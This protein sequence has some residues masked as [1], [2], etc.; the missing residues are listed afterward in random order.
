MIGDVPSRA[1]CIFIV[2]IACGYSS[3]IKFNEWRV[4]TN[5]KPRTKYNCLNVT[6]VTVS[7]HLLERFLILMTCWHRSYRKPL[8]SQ[9]LKRLQK[10]RRYQYKSLFHQWTVR[11][12]RIKLRKMHIHEAQGGIFKSIGHL[13]LKFSF[14]LWQKATA[15]GRV[16]S[17][18][19]I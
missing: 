7:C 15:A 17:W 16:L 11:P 9:R 8:R 4:L 2:L 19:L 12:T 6:D 5:N 1:D 13:A 10:S 18:S 3:P 14:P